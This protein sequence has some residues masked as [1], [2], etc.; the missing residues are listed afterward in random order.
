MMLWGVPSDVKRFLL[1]VTGTVSKSVRQALPGMVM[2]FLLTPHRRALKTIAGMVAGH[3]CH[4]GTISRR[5]DNPL[6]HT[7]DWYGILYAKTWRRVDRWERRQAKGDRRRWFVLIDTTYH[8]SVGECMENMIVMSRRKN[9]ARRTTRQHAFVMG[10]LLTD[11]GGAV[12]LANALSAV[13]RGMYAGDRQQGDRSFAS[14]PFGRDF[15]TAGD[16]DLTADDG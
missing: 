12:A 15:R 16:A 7:R 4:V 2:A 13:E 3:R 11:R 5:L 14:A 1:P 9:P 6:W 8:R 10:M